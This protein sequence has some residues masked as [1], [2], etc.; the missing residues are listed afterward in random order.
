LKSGLP[1]PLPVTSIASD[2][3]EE[4]TPQRDNQNENPYCP[5]GA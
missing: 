4:P 3:R 1:R 5:R 2:E